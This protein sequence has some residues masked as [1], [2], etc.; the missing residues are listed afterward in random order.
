[1]NLLTEFKVADQNAR[2]W[3]SV[4][5]YK[6]EEEDRAAIYGQMFAVMS[7]NATIDFDLAN[8]GSL[9]FDEL[10]Q[11]YFD[12]PAGT[13]SKGQLA[14][15]EVALKAVKRR[16]DMILSREAELVDT[17]IDIELAVILIKEK[18]LYMA[19][20]GESQIIVAREGQIANI[21]DSLIDPDNDKFMR[22]GSMFLESGDQMLL[23]TSDLAK[24][25]GEKQWQDVFAAVSTDDLNV[26][27]GAG[28]LIGM[29]VTK[30]AKPEPVV[31][32]MSAETASQMESSES[33][34]AVEHTEQASDEQV[35]DHNHHEKPV[36][37][38]DHPEQTM[39]V[40]ESELADDEEWVE[41]GP[42]IL[43]RAKQK[44]TE[45]RSV[46]QP[47]VLSGISAVR[48]TAQSKLEE[49]KERR[50]Q[51]EM[52]LEL[53]EQPGSHK[54]EADTYEGEDY[55]YNDAGG[56][57]RFEQIKRTAGSTFSAVTATVMAQAQRFMSRNVGRRSVPGRGGKMYLGG[58]NRGLNWK[59]LVPVA[60]VIFVFLFITVR[61]VVQ[62]QEYNARV[63]AVRREIT[64]LKSR[65]T[66]AEGDVR[67]ASIST[68]SVDAKEK[69]LAKLAGIE[70]DANKLLTREL[71]QT[72]IN[73]MVSDIDN[74][75]DQLQNIRGFTEPQIVADLA[76]NSE[77]TNVSD[78]TLAGGNIYVT[79]SNKGAVYRMGT[80]QRSEAT[81]FASGLNGPYLIETDED[82]D[83]IVIDN[84]TDSTVTTIDVANGQTK[85]H[86]GLSTS[87]MG[88]L[89]AIDIWSNAALYSISGEKQSLLKQDNVAGT[90]QLPNDSRPW[91][92]DADFAQARDMAVDYWVY[93]VITGKGLQRYFAGNPAPYTV[94]GLLSK[95]SEAMKNIT[96]MDITATNLYV[97][98]PTNKRILVFTK[99][100]DNGDI[101]DF[102]EQHVFR[103][104][105][106]TFT[107]IRDLVVD[108][109]G[110][111]MFVLDGNRVIRLSI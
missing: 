98:D 26:L 5:G 1:M 73:Q 78:I 3:A 109:A 83:L 8:I 81:V 70:T 104:E 50:S 16:I 91:R 17:G 54:V 58:N 99:R 61:K 82:G 44:F 105:G 96:A 31:A 47:K 38:I 7:I 95:D 21:S 74:Y 43:D 42:S 75:Q 66:D 94:N 65:L 85:R 102:K 18:V 23:L 10:Q 51:P 55:E 30:P 14:T 19:V 29:D 48:T 56:S 40:V 13:L 49:F 52:E 71:L 110:K 89:L 88:K 57:D 34:P 103:G 62:D 80:G 100:Q 92:K 36:V 4:F 68:D 97:A 64:T 46:V 33:Q 35:F 63:D 12:A 72:E 87:K 93:V 67:A 32:E 28:F 27:K 59:L 6:P 77:G 69:A 90:Y 45:I 20:V 15:L 9:L 60:L 86:T 24:L 108:E 106:S 111:V 107:D 53:E 79:D 11:A 41:V 76:A 39:P 84:N 2:R 101:F 22:T 37:S 25:Y